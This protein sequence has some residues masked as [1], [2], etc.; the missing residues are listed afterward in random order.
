[1]VL[2]RIGPVPLAARVKLLL[3]VLVVIS[4]TLFPVRVRTPAGEIELLLPKKLILPLVPLVVET[5]VKVPEEAVPPLITADPPRVKVVALTVKLAFVVKLVREDAFKLEVL[6]KLTV[7]ALTEKRPAPLFGE[8]AI[9]PVELPPMVKVLLL[10]DW[11][12]ALLAVRAIPFPL[13]VAERVAVGLPVAMPV[14]PN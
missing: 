2:R 6:F 9:L 4:G 13:V 1:L 3:T 12:V 10:S 11:M 7:P 8:I 5:R 14:T